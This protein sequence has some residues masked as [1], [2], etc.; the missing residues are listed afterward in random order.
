M[1]LKLKD[2]RTVYWIDDHPEATRAKEKWCR[3]HCSV[4]GD[5]YRRG[6]PWARLEHLGCIESELRRIHSEAR[7][8]DARIGAVM[9]GRSSLK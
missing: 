4:C 1:D 5:R 8:L 6:D 9:A 3:T 2:L 7:S